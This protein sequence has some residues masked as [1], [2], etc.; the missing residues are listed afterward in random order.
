[1][2]GS[3]FRITS[4]VTGSRSADLTRASMRA[5]GGRYCERG[6]FSH[7]RAT[8]VLAALQEESM[9]EFLRNCWYV[10]AES[11]ELAQTPVGRLLLNEPVV[12]YRREDGTPVAME[13]RCCHR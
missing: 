6:R 9:A 7:G 3:A 11:G 10:A 2:A 5:P 13:D 4:R 1:M 8:M 12:L